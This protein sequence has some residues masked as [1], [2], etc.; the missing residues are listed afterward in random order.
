MKIVKYLL[1]VALF[2][3]LANIPYIGY[4][5]YSETATCSYYL[6]KGIMPGN[7]GM[8]YKGV[9][10]NPIFWLPFMLI[11]RFLG[12]GDFIK[13]SIDRNITVE[14]ISGMGIFFIF[15]LAIYSGLAVLIFSKLY[16]IF[17]NKKF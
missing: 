2:I 17:F 1:F 7:C 15:I 9:Y 13:L 3:V 12:G 16:K 11:V 6:D 10:L 14:F 8:E 4:F 5:P